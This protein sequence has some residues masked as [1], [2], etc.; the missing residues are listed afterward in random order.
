MTLLL[1]NEFTCAVLDLFE[2]CWK[3]VC[4]FLAFGREGKIRFVFRKKTQNTH[5]HPA[6]AS[7]NNQ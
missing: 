3:K 6:Q 1:A 5:K 2:L 7:Q 4:G